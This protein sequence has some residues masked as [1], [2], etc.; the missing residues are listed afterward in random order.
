MSKPD[1]WM[2]LHVRDYLADTTHLTTEQHGA[3]CLLLM[4]AWMRGG[5]LPADDAQLAQ[6]ARM[7]PAQWKGC[8]T[9]LKP[10]FT[11]EGDAY[12]QKRLSEEYAN[13]VRIYES[14]VENGRKGGRK[15]KQKPAEKEP[16][17]FDSLNPSGGLDG[18]Q[19]QPHLPSEED[20]E[21]AG[22]SPAGLACM[23]L[24]KAGVAAVNPSNADLLALL[25]AG[26]TPEQFGD[27]ARE[28]LPG[29]SIAKPFPYLL[30]VMRSRMEAPARAQITPNTRR[31]VHDER[32]ATIAAATGAQPRRER[33]ITA[34]SDQ[35][36]R[37]HIFENG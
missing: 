35:L 36:D 7:T 28:I 24:R 18:T 30:T 34:D 27:L 12:T 17:G 5:Q 29:A 8:Q 6:I 14:K 15:S 37:A 4:A 26:A 13:A 33:D 2:P 20:G 31:T 25:D 19:P 9:V 16:T 10:F 32:A 3:Y 22:A 11:L 23:A 21:S 1:T